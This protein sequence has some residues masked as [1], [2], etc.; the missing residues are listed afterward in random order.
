[1]SGF[2]RGRPRT[3]RPVEVRWVVVP[4]LPTTPT[5]SASR[6]VVG[7]PA[8]WGRHAAALAFAAGAPPMAGFTFLAFREE[9]SFVAALFAGGLLAGPLAASALGAVHPAWLDRVRGRCPLPLVWAASA[10]P[11]A[12]AGLATIAPVWL[13]TDLRVAHWMP[14]PAALIGALVT[15]AWWPAFT[16]T[17][18]TGGRAW[19][20][21]AFAGAIVPTVFT[22]LVVA[23]YAS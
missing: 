9:L 23:L 20:A 16:F 10:V 3:R 14:G 21:T 8:H 18:V 22:A 7:T 17:T 5:P 6:R 4:E 19:L 2:Y 15:L 1:M 13:A 12:V 11:G